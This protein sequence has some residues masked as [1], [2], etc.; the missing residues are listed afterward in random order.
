MMDLYRI[1]RYRRTPDGKLQIAP[2]SPNAGGT[3]ANVEPRP[4]VASDSTHKGEAPPEGA[5]NLGNLYAASLKKKGEP[6]EVAQPDPFP[7]VKW[8]TVDDGTRE[9]GDM[10]DRAARFI[11]DQNLLLVNG[12]FRVFR[13]MV[14]HWLDAYKDRKVPGIEKIVRD[15][16]HGWYEQALVETIIGLRALTGSLE[17]S[18]GDLDAAWSEA[19][20][21]A[22]VM[23]RSHPFNA[24]KRDL[25]V[26]VASLK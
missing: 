6:G 2:P 17:W 20:L 4:A 12:D 11:E 16:V 5:G 1:S 14:K 3:G 22:V 8:I 13:D 9:P 26:K 10:E 7:R 23:Q 25:A 18:V 19:A 15:F 21:S 24:I